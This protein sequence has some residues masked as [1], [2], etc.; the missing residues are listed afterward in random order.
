MV[1]S[2]LTKGEGGRYTVTARLIGV[3][4]DAGNVVTLTQNAGRDARGVREAARRGAA[5]RRSKSLADAKA[6]IDQRT[7]KPDK[8][9]EA[10][11]KAHQD[12]AEPRAGRVLPGAARA[13]QEGAPGGGR[14]APAGRPPRATR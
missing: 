7:A 5:S 12:A 14:E 1:N 11:N 13:G 10:A 6:C 3:N 2:T 8:A 4:D 9:A